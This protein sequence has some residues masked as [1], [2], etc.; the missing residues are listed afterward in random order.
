MKTGE[1]A[2]FSG[3]PAVPIQS[4]SPFPM[5]HTIAQGESGY[6]EP[7]DPST[8]ADHDFV[9][10]RR[11]V[12]LSDRRTLVILG[13][14]AV[15]V[16][17]AVLKF[18]VFSGNSGSTPPRSVVATTVATTIPPAFASSSAFNDP[19]GY[20]SARFPGVPASSSTQ[21]DI[22]PPNLVVVNSTTYQATATIS[23]Q[24]YTYQVVV[25]QVPAQMTAQ[26]GA[27]HPFLTV[28]SI[29]QGQEPGNSSSSLQSTPQYLMEGSYYTGSFVIN[30]ASQQ[31]LVGKVII[32]GTVAFILEVQGPSAEPPGFVYFVN[33][34]QPGKAATSTL[35]ASTQASTTTSSTP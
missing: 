11:G 31:Y 7:Y 9:T 13:I 35:S 25:A 29:V 24:S 27:T 1:F 2:P 21:T 14:V 19:N 4:S 26:G 33:Q 32:V 10:P 20:F 30:S 3:V 5:A 22:L 17:A 18:T 6:G 8:F 23:G 12:S 16:L 34:F 28:E 15:V